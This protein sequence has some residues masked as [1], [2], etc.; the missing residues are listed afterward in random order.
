MPKV[1]PR[2]APDAP[3][4]EVSKDSLKAWTDAGYVE[5]KSSPAKKTAARKTAAKKSSK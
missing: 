3:S 5:V 2:G 4:L 1:V